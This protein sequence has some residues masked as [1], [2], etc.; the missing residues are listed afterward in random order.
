[1]AEKVKLTSDSKII[2]DMSL[3]AESLNSMREASENLCGQM[4]SFEQSSIHFK[5]I[6]DFDR[7]R[8]LNPLN[9]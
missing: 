9:L 1:M 6:S 7:V 5:M 2:I 4:I 8:K 3:C